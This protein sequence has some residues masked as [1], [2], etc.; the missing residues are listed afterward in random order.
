MLVDLTSGALNMVDVL[1]PVGKVTAISHVVVNVVL[2]KRQRK[3]AEMTY[4]Q[5]DIFQVLLLAANTSGRPRS[6]ELRQV[7]SIFLFSYSGFGNLLGRMPAN[8]MY[9]ASSVSPGAPFYYS[10]SATRRRARVNSGS[11]TPI[12]TV[13][14]RVSVL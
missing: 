14:I 1:E 9:G 6:L 10:D 11:Q 12:S 5:L 4:G 13:G 7:L 2:M 8:L 3:P